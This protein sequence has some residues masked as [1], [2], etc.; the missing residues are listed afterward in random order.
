M[1]TTL[2]SALLISTALIASPVFAGDN[3]P[4]QNNPGLTSY[5]IARSTGSSTLTRAQVRDAVLA[6][7]QASKAGKPLTSYDAFRTYPVEA[8]KAAG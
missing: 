5:S 8:A 1:K 3:N 7:Q 4:G 2:I 6:S